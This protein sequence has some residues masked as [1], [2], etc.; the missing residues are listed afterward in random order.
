MPSRRTSSRRRCLGRIAGGMHAR[1][2]RERRTAPRASRPAHSTAAASTPAPTAAT[3][4]AFSADITNPWFPFPVGRHY[5]Y[6]GTKD[7]KKA[8]DKVVVS[9]RTRVIDGAECRLVEDKLYLDGVLEERTTDYYTQAA[10]GAVWYYGEDTAE[11]DAHGAVTSTEGSVD[12]RGARR[13]GGRHR[14]PRRLAW[15]SRW[16]RSGIPDTLRTSSG[17]STLGPASRCRTPLRPRRCSPRSG[18][19]W[20]RMCST[21]STTCAASGW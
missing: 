1:Q 10:D 13:S 2:G 7:G 3:A 18:H 6:V 21:T 15:V 20:S 19:R 14:C 9:D 17:C 4:R 12:G 5:T 16:H 11:L 8:V